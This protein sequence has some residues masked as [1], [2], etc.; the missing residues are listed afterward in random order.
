MGFVRKVYTILFVQFLIIT[1][2]SVLSLKVEDFAM[3]MLFDGRWVLGLMMSFVIFAEIALFCKHSLRR[4][5]PYN[6]ILLSLFTI[7]FSWTVAFICCSSSLEKTV[8]HF[9]KTVSYYFSNK[10]PKYIYLT[11]MCIITM[12]CTTYAYSFKTFTFLGGVLMVTS[13]FLLLSCCFIGLIFNQT[14]G[15]MLFLAI[16]GLLFGIYLIGDMQL[17]ISKGNHKLSID[18][19]IAGALFLYADPVIVILVIIAF[20]GEICA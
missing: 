3:W 11:M 6:Y 16:F 14:F 19:Y 7:G 5:A 13:M 4:K 17:F 12:A 20:C 10:G 1:A 9:P 8:T 18:D 15:F 2:F